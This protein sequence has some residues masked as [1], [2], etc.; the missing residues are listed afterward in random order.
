VIERCQRFGFALESYQPVGIVGECFWKRLDRDI[1]FQSRV[2][3]AI[4]FSH[5]TLAQA[6]KTSYV[7]ME[8][9]G[10]RDISAR[11]YS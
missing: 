1:A 7:P 4:D 8:L 9:P 5:A 2:A 6:A 10:C 3:R 11:H